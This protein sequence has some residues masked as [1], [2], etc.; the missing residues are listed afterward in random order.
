MKGAKILNFCV[1]KAG[2]DEIRGTRTRR[3]FRGSLV[4]KKIVLKTAFMLV[5][6]GRGTSVI[7]GATV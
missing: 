4:G 1:I 6:S 2:I 7:I 5:N 3:C